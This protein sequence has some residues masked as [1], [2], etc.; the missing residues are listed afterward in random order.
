MQP[1]IGGKVMPPIMELRPEEPA[2]FNPDKLE[3]LCRRMGEAR[4]EAE[5]AV[6]L[7]RIS[8]A[9]PKIR[10]LLAS[11]E[12]AFVAG[13]EQMIADAEL[14]GMATLSRVARSVLDSFG[15]E[16]IVALSATMAR[17]ERVGDRSIHAVWDLEDLSG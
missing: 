15:T 4:A 8:E 11:D 16:N 1:S 14:I 6:A 9:L 3:D 17:L 7:H 12:A 2:R 5:V 13:L 10:P